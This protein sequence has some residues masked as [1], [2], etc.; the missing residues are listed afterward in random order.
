MTDVAVFLSTRRVALTIPIRSRCYGLA[1][2]VVDAVIGQ[3]DPARYVLRLRRVF[4]TA[5]HVSSS[6][7]RRPGFTNIWGERNYPTFA[8]PFMTECDGTKD[9]FLVRVGNGHF[10]VWRGDAIAL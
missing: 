1:D 4:M 6:Y 2:S 5:V 10:P 7:C 9:D 8:I 3:E